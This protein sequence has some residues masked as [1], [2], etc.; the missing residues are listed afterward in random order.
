MEK[1]RT[2]IG[3]GLLLNIAIIVFLIIRIIWVGLDKFGLQMIG[4]CF[5]LSLVCFAFLDMTKTNKQ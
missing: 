3:V 5:V 2:L 1:I 4:T